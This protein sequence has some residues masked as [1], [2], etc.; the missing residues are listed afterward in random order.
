MIRENEGHMLGG[1]RSIVTADEANMVVPCFD[2]FG[3]YRYFMLMKLH[4]RG[5]L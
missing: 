5:Q 2:L 1:D 3:S 4:T